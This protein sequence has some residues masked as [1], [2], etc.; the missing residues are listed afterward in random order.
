MFVQVWVEISCH[1]TEVSTLWVS[2]YFRDL[3][4]LRFE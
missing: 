3:E 1:N 2:Q 4:G